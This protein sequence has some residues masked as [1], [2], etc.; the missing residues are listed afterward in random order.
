MAKISENTSTSSRERFV[1]SGKLKINIV[2][3]GDVHAR[4]II[5]LHG[6]RAYAR[7]WDRVASVLAKNYYVIALDQRGRGLSDWAPSSDYFTEYYVED[8][9]NVVDSLHLEKFI[10]LGH[11]MGGATSL[12]F[13][14]MYPNYLEGMVIEDIGPGS[15]A[16]SSGADRIKKELKQTPRVFRSRTEAKLFWQQERPGSPD[17]AIEQRLNYMMI[18]G[19]DSKMRWRYDLEGI[20]HARLNPDDSKIPDLWPPILKLNTPTLVLRGGDSDFLSAEIMSEMVKSNPNI[21]AF[22]ISGASHYVHDDNFEEFMARLET[23]LEEL[24][25]H[26]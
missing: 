24:N 4:P 9:K 7:T 10:L 16:S 12:V 8:L 15:S 21:T 18:E 5:M 6:L 17:E 1:S 20:A 3:W 19:Q 26:I 11:S 25:S 14:Q 13:S 2:E 23:F 22:E